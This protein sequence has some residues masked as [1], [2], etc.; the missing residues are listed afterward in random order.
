MLIQGYLVTWND[1]AELGGIGG[2]HR[3]RFIAGAFLDPKGIPVLHAHDRRLVLAHDVRVVEDTIGASFEADIDVG[4]RAA[5]QV[6]A[7]VRRGLIFGVSFGFRPT[8]STWV[9]DVHEIHAA[10]LTEISICGW[11]RYPRSSCWIS[12]D[13]LYGAPLYLQEL[14]AAYGRVP[15]LAALRHEAI[16][17]KAK[18]PLRLA[19]SNPAPGRQ[20][21]VKSRQP[22][23]IG[24]S[25]EAQCIRAARH[26]HMRSYLSR[27]PTWTGPMAQV[28]AR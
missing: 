2:E 17:A 25:K 22:M 24:A 4:N 11:P 10:E 23:R 16:L 19:A 28:W 6:V 26:D 14:A 18:P 8:A 1:Q 15:T 3:E 21:P 13:T 20:K 12:G 9:N 27:M 5:R 7:C